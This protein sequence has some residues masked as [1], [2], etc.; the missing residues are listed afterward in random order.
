MRAAR[1]ALPAAAALA[2]AAA[3]AAPAGGDA[4]ARGP[5]GVAD[6]DGDFIKD[7][8]DNCPLN[9]N[10]SQK[11][12]DADTPP[13]VIDAGR[14]PEPAGQNTGP[15]RLYP[16]TPVQTGQPLPT[17]H[18]RVQGGDACDLDDDNDGVYDR[19]SAG[20]KGPD[21]CRFV[22]NPGQEDTDADGIG[23]ACDAEV[24]APAEPVAQVRVRAP[25]AVRF[26]AIGTGVIVEARCSA[27]CRLAGELVLDRRSAPRMKVTGGRLVLGRGTAALAGAGRTFLVVRV[28]AA[29]RRNLERR[30]RRVRPLL[31]V[32][33]LGQPSR[34]VARSRVLL[35]R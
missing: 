17:D 5:C 25:R 4:C 31:R 10:A 34:T 1:I 2:A 14:P 11:D 32:T 16:A 12:S 7:W 18:S 24:N 15:V 20:R 23:D 26:D 19:R 9:G 8:A 35:R 21:N 33:A 6:Y 30:L 3:V 28:P 29:S 13:P 22:P 27:A